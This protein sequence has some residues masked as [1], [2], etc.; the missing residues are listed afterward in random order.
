MKRLSFEFRD[1]YLDVP[2]S[3]M[4]GMRDVLIHQYHRIDF[5]D[6]EGVLNQD[7]PELLPKLEKIVDELG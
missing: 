2:W 4:A 3:D 1:R 5:D 7:L 6:V